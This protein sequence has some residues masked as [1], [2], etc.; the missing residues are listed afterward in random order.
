[1]KVRCR[2]LSSRDV[3]EERGARVLTVRGHEM[4]EAQGCSVKRYDLQGI[5]RKQECASRVICD[6]S[7]RFTSR[8]LKIGSHELNVQNSEEEQDGFVA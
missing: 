8:E 1:M 5:N 6:Q 4:G 2:F 3:R 7:A